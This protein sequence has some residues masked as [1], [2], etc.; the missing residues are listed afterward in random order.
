MMGKK[1]LIGKEIG[2]YERIIQRAPNNFEAYHK[3]IALLEYLNRHDEAI[4]TYE[5]LIKL[6]PR[7]HRAYYR[8]GKSYFMY[9]FFRC[10]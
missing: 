2:N 1:D 6:D 7:A 8:K 5:R 4:T 3:K 9:T 10:I